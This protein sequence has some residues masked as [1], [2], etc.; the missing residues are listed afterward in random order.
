MAQSGQ[1]GVPVLLA[2]GILLALVV[3]IGIFS[4]SA[5]TAPRDPAGP[6]AAPV[7]MSSVRTAGIRII[8]PAPV[9]RGTI[10]VEEALSGRRSVRK[11]SPDPLSL[12]DISQLLWAS[13]GITGA[14]GFRTTPSAGA[15]YP[16]EIYVA[17]GN[18][19]G[20][21]AGVYHYLPASHA[22]EMVADRDIR[23]D[24]CINALNQEPIRDAPAV[25]LIAADYNRTLQKYGD[26]GVRYVHLE[27][28]HAAQNLYL[29]AYALGEGTVAIGAFDDNGIQTVAGLP[30]E[31]VP[32]YLMPVGNIR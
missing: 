15:V 29:Q 30:P 14:Q 26:R 25:L 17:A 16:L 32:L 31:Q 6:D 7:A 12:S 20:L 28:G 23:T 19:T 4:V 2:A 5:P 21:P 18:V 11:Y 1:H 13:Q 27:A 24:L 8:L 10:S 22:L 9:T 3:V